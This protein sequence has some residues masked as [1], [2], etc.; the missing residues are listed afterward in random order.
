MADGTRDKSDGRTIFCA[1][2][3]IGDE[4]VEATVR[5]FPL[6]GEPDEA[7]RARA[8]ALL[9]AML[10]RAVESLP[11]DPGPMVYSLTQEVS[12]G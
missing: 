8:H 3:S 4:T 5:L 2:R 12:R 6:A 7:H 11:V 9:D 10:D 1:S